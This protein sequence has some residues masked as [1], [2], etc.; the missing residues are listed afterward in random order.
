ML[1]ALVGKGQGAVCGSQVVASAEFASG[2]TV[3]KDVLYWADWMSGAKNT[4]S[5]Q[6]ESYTVSRS[7]VDC[8]P[9]RN[10]RI[11]RRSPSGLEELMPRECLA[12]RCRL[13]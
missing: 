12:F 5:H 8:Q 3:N 9:Q 4:A 6:K 11:L 1:Q 2:V 13:V 10:G 7:S